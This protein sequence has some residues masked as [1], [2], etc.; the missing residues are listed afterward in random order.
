MATKITKTTKDTNG[1]VPRLAKNAKLL[2]VIVEAI[3][4]KKGENILSLDLRDIP[5]AVADFFIVCEASSTTQVKAI[6]DFIEVEV[7]EKMGE[8]PFHSEGRQSLNWVLVDYVN[9]VI[10]IMLPETRKLYSLEELW[11]DAPEQKF[12][13][14]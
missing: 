9:V 2:K 10:H 6:G 1:K 8:A 7:K 12:D 3:Q 13:H 5:E 4:T 11:C 14:Y